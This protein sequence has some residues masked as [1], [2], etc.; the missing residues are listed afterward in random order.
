MSPE[1]QFTETQ[2]AA[3]V[4]AIQEAEK[5]T[6]GE[7]RIHFDRHCG[8]SALE[9]ATHTF[10]RLGMSQTA[11]KNGVLIYVALEDKKLAIIGDQGINEKVPADFWDSIKD[12]MIERFRAGEICEGVC[13]AVLETGIQLKHYFPYQEDDINEL[14]DDISFQK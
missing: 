2:K 7:I 5:S 1:E 4:A 11:L 8:S 13:E 10:S 12:R 14:P 9:S 6:S 3:M